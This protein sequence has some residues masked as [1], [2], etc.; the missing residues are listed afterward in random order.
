MSGVPG[1]AGDPHRSATALD[2]F[3]NEQRYVLTR[4]QTVAFYASIGTRVALELYDR[5]RPVSYT[6]TTYLDT[7]DFSYFRS[8]DGPV[9]RRLRVREYAVAAAPG[10]TA[11]LSGVC[12]LE[13]KQSSG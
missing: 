4:A 9:A 7:E 13:L 10:D 12:F 11:F 1:S 3:E 2:P 6:R 5:S 8:C